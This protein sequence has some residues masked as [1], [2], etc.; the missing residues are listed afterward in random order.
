M[1]AT[2]DRQARPATAHEQAVLARWSGWGALPGIFDDE[3]ERWATERSDLRAR[4]DDT[5]WD[6]ARRTV[7]NA[8]YSSAEVVRAV[9]GLLRDLGF[10]GGRVLEPGCGSGNFIGLAP[11]DLDVAMVGVELDRTTARVAA[12]LYP[13]AEVRAEGF[14]DSAFGSGTFDAAVGNVPF[15]KVV[16]HSP[17]HNRGR[18]SLHNFCILKSLDLTRP[19]GLV[20]VLTSRFTLDARNP[21][22]RREMAEMAD[23]VG[24]L[25]LPA[26]ALR[27]SAGTDAVT[28]LV[29]LRRREDGRQPREVAWQRVGTVEAE[30]GAVEVNEYFADRPHRVL[31]TLVAGGGQYSHHD[32]DVRATEAPLAEQMKEAL[33]G[34]VA[35]ADAA[36]L[37][38][39]PSRPG[40][41]ATA[42]G[43]SAPGP[44]AVGHKEGA[45]VAGPRGGFARVRE[46]RLSAYRARPEKDALELAA[47]VAMRDTLVRLLDLEGTD[48]DDAAPEA[49]RAELN[50]L[51][52]AYSARWGPLNRFTLARTGRTHPGTGEQLYRRQYPAMGGF[53]E[54]PDFPSLCALEVFDPDA[55]TARK[56]P[57]L[58]GRMLVPRAPARGADAAED[59]LAICLDERGRPELS[60]IA[61]LLGTTEAEARAEL[62][63]LVWDDP[64]TGDLVEASRYLSGNV[65]AKLAAAGAAAASD[66]GWRANVEALEAVLPPDLGPAEIDARLGSSWVPASDVARFMVEVLGC[67]DPVVEYTPQTATWHLQVSTADRGRVASRSEW[68]TPRADAPSLVLASLNQTPASVYD[69]LDDGRRVLNGGETVAAREKQ[70]AIGERFRSWAWEDAGRRERLVETYNR[71]FN[72]HVVPT[73]DGGHLS[74]PGLAASF[75][76]HRHQR[77]AAWRMVCEPTVLLAHEVGAGKTATL[78]MGVLEQRRLG[79]V[80]KPAFVVPNHLV[81]QFSRELAQLY[82]AG[83]FL[84]ASPKDTSP[85]GRKEF[86]ARCATGDWDGVVITASAFARIPVSEQTQRR[87]IAEQIGELRQAIAASTA[88]LSVKRLEEQVARMEERHKRLLATDRRD[89]GVTWEA[90]GIDYIALDESHGWKNLAFASRVPGV[91][92]AGSQKAE[93][94]AMKL[95]YLRSRHD[96]WVATFA[97]ATPIANS[98]AEMWVVQTYL[99]P[100]RLAEAGIG[101]FDA[102][103]ANFGRTVTALELAPDGGSYRLNTRFARFANVPELLAMFRAVAD[104]R[105]AAQLDLD[106]PAVAGGEARTVVVEASHELRDYVATLVQ[107]AED[108]RQRRVAPDEDNMLKVTGD[109]RKAALDLRLVGGTPDPTGGKIAA[110]AAEVARRFHVERDRPY[111]DDAGRAHPRPG[112]LQVVFC[113]LGTPK[114]DGSWSAYS[115]LREQLVRRGV[116][117]GMVRFVHDAGDD[118]AKAELFAAC[119]DGR[120]GVLIGSTEKMGVG[121]NVQARLTALHHLDCPWRPAD[122]AQRDGRAVRQGNQNAEVEIVRYVTQESFD[123]YSWQTVARKAAFIHQVMSGEIVGREVDDDM[124]ETALSYAEVKALATGNPLILEKAGVDSELARLVRL[125][126]AHDRD[127]AGLSR[128]LARGTEAA[129]RLGDEVVA[130]QEALDRRRPTTGDNF[131]MTVEGTTHTARADAGAHLQRVLVDTLRRGDD[132]ARVVGELGGVT[133]HLARRA[134]PGDAELVLRLARTPVALRLAGTEL[135]RLE[136]LGLVSRLEH[137]LRG[138]DDTLEQTRADLARVNRESTAAKARLGAPF[139]HDDRLRF[140]RSRQAE[141]EAALLPD[142]GRASA[143]APDPAPAPDRPG[144]EAAR[145][146][147]DL[148]AW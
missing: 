71:L 74:F 115:E 81:S 54:D 109:G 125:R 33:A 10:E 69:T 144:P 21:S 65:R 32:L 118:R 51:Y 104:V 57:I 145:P 138:L 135:A 30:G 2:L 8:H 44:E 62:G 73:Y 56:A 90:S 124:G 66:P 129:A 127:Q 34:I 89:D 29:V 83:R 119:R 140:L 45:I 84:V 41:A 27:A 75:T 58:G 37:R 16:P 43:W 142:D 20:A 24:A 77:D 55:R 141:I 6:A 61:D 85:A 106:V 5:E 113:D 133:V 49:Q 14:Q 46:G 105:G 68:G 97:T 92:G 19:G 94:L 117:A 146:G 12:A 48:P 79:L 26:G 23:L 22:A 114:P 148:G 131:A 132:Q 139:P 76:P 17:R 15:S 93:D 18:H 87:F 28:D 47:L 67:S 31:G 35:E 88:G 59:A 7:L 121:T 108:I 107:R 110:A 126:Q 38:W 143:P 100:G 70:E 120:V 99:Q 103:A 80:R 39:S 101:G 3:D 63:R 96:E 50:R 25:R 36:G 4:L 111:L 82:P 128:T 64:A 60:H 53:R 91:G 95:G 86:I 147:P 112:S 136:P 40:A 42:V 13:H 52:D 72:S 123:V 1:L 11:E 102:W 116:P 122:L 134:G 9:W 130:L 78:A 98:L 137:R